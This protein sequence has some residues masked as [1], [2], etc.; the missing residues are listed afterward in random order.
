MDARTAVVYV[1]TGPDDRVV[2]FFALAA[3]TV[4]QA[5]APPALRRQAGHNPIPVILLA[6]LGV[7]TAAQGVGLGAALVKDAMV[8]ASQAAG[9]IGARAL[10]VH[11]ESPAAR[12][13][14]LHL[15]EFDVSPTDDL[16][17]VLLIRGIEELLNG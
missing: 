17:L 10:V 3:A 4:A 2:G 1:V 14:Y 9:S 11:A 5:D 7:D 6:R 12:A 16:H 15:A 13:F 8:R